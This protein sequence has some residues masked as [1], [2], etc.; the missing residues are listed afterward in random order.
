[1]TVP[2]DPNH[3]FD[4]I[5][6]ISIDTRRDRREDAKKQFANI[7]LL[8]RVEFVIVKKHPENREEGIFQSHMICINKG[9]QAGGKHILIFE[10]DI[11]I[12]KFQ[13]QSLLSAIDFLQKI[14]SWNSFLLG[15]I[16]SKITATDEQSVVKLQY[17]SLA[18]A[19]ALNRPFAEHLTR[20]SWDGTP[21]DELLR[22]E[23]KD[24]YALSPMI[25]FQSDTSTDNQRIL[26][27]RVRRLLGGLPFIQR[28]NEFFQR[29]KRVIVYSHLLL[30][31]A[32]LLLLIRPWAR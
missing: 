26:L 8:N 9:L 19:Y 31:M 21:F 18:H 32:F 30:T 22:Q 25:A 28:A 2:F 1:M 24:Y 23:C 15:A 3:F 4:K 13:P 7:G 16:S 20:R 29:Y 6:C 17:R 12:K 5:Y 27:D 10:D 14:P 11:L